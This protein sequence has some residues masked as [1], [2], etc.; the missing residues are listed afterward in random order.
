VGKKTREADKAQLDELRELVAEGDGDGA[1][2]K[3]TDRR[4]MLR[5]AGAA[6]L[7]AAGMA[8]VKVIP[9]AAAN[10]GAVILGA[11]NT[12]TLPTSV[13]NSDTT[14]L[15]Y[16]IAGSSPVTG[17]VGEGTGGSSEI[18]VQGKST[19]GTGIGVMG[20]TLGLAAGSG[21]GVGVQGLATTG[22]GVEGEASGA[23]TGVLGTAGAAGNGVD[24]AGSTGR[25]G[26]FTS[27]TGYD[28][29]LGYPVLGGYVGSGRLG[30]VGRDDTGVSAPPVAPAFFVTSTGHYTFEH[31]LVRGTDS[32][33]WASRYAAAGTDQSRWKRINTVRVD[34]ND[35]LGSSFKP[36]R[37]ID[38]RLVGGI[39]AGG[40]LNPVP[41]AGRGT[42]TS[43]IPANAVAVMGN[44]TAVD[45]TGSG[46]LAIMPAGITLGTGATQYD[47]A[48][49][50]STVNFQV[51][52]AAIANSFVCGLSNGQVQ[53][54]VAKSSSQFIIDITAYME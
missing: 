34:S 20:T 43:T 29:A 14:V 49:D 48:R 27:T 19:S 4:A 30:M 18:G 22:I 26:L 50:P 24:G 52:Q 32:S 3:K 40:T 46:F 51:G 10:G 15:S 6:V 53:V 47:T 23:G 17:L 42:G 1:L 31:E 37:V 11:S 21:T 5:L 16:A 45:Y 25:G 8:A 44:L 36:F 2:P 33:I 35:G 13:A 12:A 38:T 28:V 41:V 7:G 54:Y 39:R 9:A